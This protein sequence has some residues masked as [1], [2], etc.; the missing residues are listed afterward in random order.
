[1]SPLVTNLQLQKSGIF[2]ARAQSHPS[3][4]SSSSQQVNIAVAS[5]HY[6]LAAEYCHAFASKVQRPCHFCF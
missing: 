5:T 1:M 2:M 3:L 6:T 4:L